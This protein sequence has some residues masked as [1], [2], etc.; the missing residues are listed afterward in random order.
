MGFEILA[1]VRFGGARSLAGNFARTS[2][3]IDTHTSPK[4]ES[5][6][7]SY[8]AECPRFGVSNLY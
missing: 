2:A 4:Q 7:E 1:I 5:F 8:V 6:S 3:N